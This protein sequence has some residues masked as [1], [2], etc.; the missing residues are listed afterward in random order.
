MIKYVIALTALLFCLFGF[1]Q[2]PKYRVVSIPVQRDGVWLRDPWVG[3]M[4]A[5]QFSAC[6]LNQDGTKDLFVFDRDGFQ[7]LTYLSNGNCTD[8]MF[9][10]APQYESLFPGGLG[11]YALIR[12]YNN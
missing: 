8:S 7:V 10:Y 9:E 11:Q 12:D 4:N 3:G 5:P 2:S 1:T 6:D